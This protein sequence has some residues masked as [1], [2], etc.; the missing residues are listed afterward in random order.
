MAGIKSHD[1]NKQR[2]KGSQN[3]KLLLGT[4]VKGYG[5]RRESFWKSTFIFSFSLLRRK[6]DVPD[7][8]MDT[9]HVAARAGRSERT[10][11]TAC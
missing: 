11:H 3:Q 4:K 6:G 9:E 7:L 10:A 8:S 1:A 5:K 2:K